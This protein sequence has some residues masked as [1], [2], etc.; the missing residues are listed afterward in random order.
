MGSCRFQK[1]TPEAFIQILMSNRKIF[2]VLLQITKYTQ[3]RKF[4]GRGNIFVPYSQ[5][6]HAISVY[7][8]PMNRGINTKNFDVQHMFNFRK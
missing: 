4:G 1:L 8:I 7:S 6:N 5:T 2:V 3:F